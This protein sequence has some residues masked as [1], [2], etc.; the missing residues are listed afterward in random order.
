MALLNTYKLSARDQTFQADRYMHE[1]LL[2]EG[3]VGGTDYKV[4]AG[5]ASLQWSVA[6]GMAWVRGDDTTRQGLYP[7][8][9]DAAVTGLV[10]AGHATL[11]R[12]DQV[13]LQI[14]DSS[15]SGVSDTPTLSTL[16]G[17]ATAGATLD[18]RNGA[19]ALPNS[20]LRIADILVPATHSGVLTSGMF[21][22]RRSWARGGF[23]RIVRNANAAAGNDYTT[24]STSFV[25]IDA[26]NL[27]VRMECTGNPMR[28]RLVGSLSVGASPVTWDVGFMQD[29]TQITDAD[30]QHTS[31]N[32]GFLPI[33]AESLIVPAAGSHTFAPSW[34][35]GSSTL[36]LL[37]R[38]A[39]A[40][41][42]IVEEIAIQ[43]ADNS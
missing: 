17:T 7:Q 39:F 16:A 18:N 37:A 8:V 13:I 29:G 2:Q 38:A 9:N 10:A 36:T 3:V 35:T 11:P 1:S 24:T 41:V 4:S 14:A 21:R 34:K 43:N 22:D 31:P 26:T 23:R 12:L 27:L 20:A 15:V 42:F 25:A 5:G 32:T 6:A 40:A 33:A 28:L 30:L 19:A